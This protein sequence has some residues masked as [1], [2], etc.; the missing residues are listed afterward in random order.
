VGN[1]KGKDMTT[2]CL[3]PFII[4]TILAV[5]ASMRSSQLSQREEQ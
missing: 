5:A 4:V 2:Y 1:I 3:I